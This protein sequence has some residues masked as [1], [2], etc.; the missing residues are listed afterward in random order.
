[1]ETRQRVQAKAGRDAR[2]R[3]E[4]ANGYSLRVARLSL[5]VFGL[6]KQRRRRALQQRELPDGAVATILRNVRFFERLSVADQTELLGHVRIFLA[7][8]RF[9]GCAGFVVTDEVRLTIAA[10]AC[11]LLSHRKTDY[12]PRLLT[13]LVYPSTYV[14]ERDEPLSAHIW[15]GGP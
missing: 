9:E 10:Q 7:E 13:I 3:G 14:V 8:K 2:A 11:L 5:A 15:E 6:F 1:M 4:V 12:F